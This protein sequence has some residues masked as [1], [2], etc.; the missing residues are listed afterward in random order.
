MEIVEFLKIL[1]SFCEK[2]EDSSLND[3]QI[4]GMNNYG[5]SLLLKFF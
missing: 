4:A 3:L 5:I 1:L 2:N